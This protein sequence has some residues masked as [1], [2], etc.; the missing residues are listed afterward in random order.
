MQE[1][2]VN[3]QSNNKNALFFNACNGEVSF[4]A[5]E[6]TFMLENIAPARFRKGYM[7]CVVLKL[8]STKTNASAGGTSTNG[9]TCCLTV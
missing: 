8:L 9:L 7:S 3:Y 1:R 6:P 4:W 5:V 2:N